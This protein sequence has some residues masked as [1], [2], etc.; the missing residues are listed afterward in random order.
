MV[1]IANTKKQNFTIKRNGMTMVTHSMPKS[2][3]KAMATEMSMTDW[4]Y[5]LIDC[6]RCYTII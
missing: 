2:V 5:W 4:S 6:S 3:F 1:I